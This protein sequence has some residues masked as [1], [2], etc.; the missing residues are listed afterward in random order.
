MLFG[1]VR[2]AV[3]GVL[4]KYFSGKDGSA[5]TLEKLAHLAMW[6]RND[7]NKSLNQMQSLQLS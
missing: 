6:L 4:S 3:F 1:W 5:S 2:W 7:D